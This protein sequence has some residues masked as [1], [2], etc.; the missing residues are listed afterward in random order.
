MVNV[1]FVCSAN[2][3]R[4]PAAEE[5]F[6]QQEMTKHHLYDSAWT[7][8]ERVIR[9]I[10]KWE[11]EDKKRFHVPKIISLQM[12]LKNDLIFVME[13]HH[14]FVIKKSIETF[15]PNY[16][17]EIMQKLFILKISDEFSRDDNS[18]QKQLRWLLH[19]KLTPILRLK[20]L[21]QMNKLS[22]SSLLQY[23]W[24]K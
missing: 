22:I 9:A 7:N 4:S 11:L 20:S 2:K 1:L 15:K 3:D 23:P 10:N 5:Y 19:E 12:F 16:Q 21:W 24:L 14:A 13:W 6:S 8:P 17:P 18:K